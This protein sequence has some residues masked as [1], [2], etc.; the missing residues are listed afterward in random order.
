LRYIVKS[1]LTEELLLYFNGQFDMRLKFDD[2]ED[3][4]DMLKLR[5]SALAPDI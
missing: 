1:T 4:L 3:F 2:R 5:F